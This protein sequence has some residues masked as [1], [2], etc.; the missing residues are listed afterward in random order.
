MSIKLSKVKQHLE[1]ILETDNFDKL[2]KLTDA[3]NKSKK[4]V[5]NLLK[6]VREDID[7]L[8]VLKLEIGL[9]TED[10]RDVKLY[11][12]QPKYVYVSELH[13]NLGNKLDTEN[14]EWINLINSVRKERYN[15]G[16]ISYYPHTLPALGNI[17]VKPKVDDIMY[18]EE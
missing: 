9:T 8:N 6:I 14:M 11:L 12:F 16:P 13:Q 10:V 3:S 18:I 2:I 4:T 17:Q 15:M 5:E 1:K 7:P